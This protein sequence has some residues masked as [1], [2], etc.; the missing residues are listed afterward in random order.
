MLAMLTADW[1]PL[2]RDVYFRKFELYPLSFQQEVSNNNLLVA[3][4]YGG[5]IAVTKNPK[6]FVKVQGSNKSMIYLY[7]SAGKLTAKLQWSGGQL[8]NFGWSQQEELL[9]IQDNGLVHIYDM[10]GTYQHAFTMGNEVQDTKV[11]EAKFFVSSGGTG[12]AVLTSTYH[13]FL[14]NNIVEPKVR[15][16]SQVPGYGGPIDCWCL[17]HSNRETQVILSNKDGIFIVHQAHQSPTHIPFATLFTTQNKVSS[18]VAMAVSGNNRHIALY[19]DTGQLYL[20]SI[21]FKETYCNYYANTKETLSNIA[22]CGTEAVVCSWDST[23]MVVGR[24]AETIVYTYDGPVHL[25]TEID[26]IRVLSSSSHEMIQKVPSVVLKIFRI[27][28]TDPASYLL[29]AS[30]QFQKKS[31]KADSY[32]DLVKSKLDAAVNACIGGAGH[33]FDFETQKLLMRAAKFGKGFSK[34]INAEYFVTMCRTLRILNAVR[35][36]AIGIPL[37]YA[38]Y[39][40]LTSQ[41]LL[42][43]LVAR[44]HYYL[45]IQIARHLKLPEIDG[46]SRILAHWACYKVKQT[47]LDK[48][49]IAEEIADKLGYAPGV[50]YSEIAKRAADCGRKQLAIKLIDYEPR[51]HQ[52]VP[53]LLTLGEERAALRKAVE[54]GNTDLVYTVILHLRQ[55]MTLGDFQMY[56]K[57]CPLA[58]ALYVKYCQNHN[59]ETLRDI[60]NQYDDFHSQ[61]VWFITESYQ[62]KNTMTREALLQSAQENFKMARN[63]TNAALTEEQIKLL[64]YQRTL[65]DTLHKSIVGKPLHDT[66]K[67]LLLS[68]ELKLADKLRSEYRI[69]DR[70]YWWLRIQCLAENKLW[71]DLE[72]FSKSKKSPIGYEPFID[73]CLIYDEHKKEAKK[74][75][76][77]VKDELK[78]KYLVKLKMLNEAVDVAVEQKDASALTFV[79]AQCEPSNRQ[80]IDKINMFL[81][82]FRN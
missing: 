33:E 47:Q 54:S 2:G 57:H 43:R 71:E 1:F 44:R 75:L 21:D 56:I 68:K 69:P 7:T 30:V 53:L 39:T 14:V 5:S 23:I 66:V 10:F 72:K 29:E 6:K 49:Q 82:S 15:Q 48:E 11:I 64:R 67:L 58:M 76:P 59:R 16:V 81:T 74:Y 31:H 3:A 65:E 60:Y 34:T 32:I 38:Q 52:Q 62:R 26:G 19:A 24:T 25:V 18:V 41:V 27:N 70:R 13:I 35:H 73:Q 40:V 45:S 61:A 28:S 42:D 63:D 50:S 9:C 12:I 80:L 46:E 20:G 17:V 78:V 79:L 77:K 55:K 4:P 8:I 36:P 37:T 22:W 51:A